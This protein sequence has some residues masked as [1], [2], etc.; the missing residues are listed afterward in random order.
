M[1]HIAHPI[2]AEGNSSEFAR[3][4]HHLSLHGKIFFNANLPII[5]TPKIVTNEY[6]LDMEPRGFS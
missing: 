5:V 1:V 4:L 6:V 3:Y 2:T